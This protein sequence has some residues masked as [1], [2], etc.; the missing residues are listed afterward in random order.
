MTGGRVAEEMHLRHRTAR[1][2]DIEPLRD[3]LRGDGQLRVVIAIAAEHDRDRPAHPRP[4]GIAAPP[5]R[6]VPR[7]GVWIRAEV[8]PILIWAIHLPVHEYVRWRGPEHRRGPGQRRGPE[9]RALHVV[10][11]D[12]VLL[13]RVRVLALDLD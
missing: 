11:T 8:L 2:G 10:E 13:V 12:D 7:F 9:C 3:V 5:Q 4:V 6:Y 1:A